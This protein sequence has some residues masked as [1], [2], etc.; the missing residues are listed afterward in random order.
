[1]AVTGQAKHAIEG[2]GGARMVTGVVTLASGAAN[3]THGLR[4]CLVFLTFVDASVPPAETLG[5]IGT[6]VDGWLLET[7]G[8]TAVESSNVSSTENVQYLVIGF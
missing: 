1:M 2:F 4:R 5:A 3:I 8:I 7:D 6:P